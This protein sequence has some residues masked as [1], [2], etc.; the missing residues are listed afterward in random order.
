[1]KKKVLT[2]LLVVTMLLSAIP[3]FANGNPSFVVESVTAKAGETIDVTISVVNNP[4]IAS[5][6]LKVNYDTNLILNSV[7]YNT[8]IG[9]MSMQPQKLNSPVTLNWFN[10]IADTNGDWVFATL[11]F[12]VADTAT[13]G[14]CPITVTYEADNVYNIAEEN[15]TFEIENGGV[16][17][18]CSHEAKTE[19]PSKSADCVNSGNNL[20]YICDS[21]GQAF[22]T[23]G[24]TKTT[25]EA[26]TIPAL[27]HDYNDPTCTAPKTCKRC[28]VTEGEALGHD[29]V[30]ATCTAPKTCKRCGVTEGEALGHTPSDWQRDGENHWKNCAVCGVELEKAAHSDGDGNGAC[31]ACGYPMATVKPD[32]PATGDPTSILLL[33]V[34]LLSSGACLTAMIK[35]RKV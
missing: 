35:R 4:G 11:S 23:D 27:G 29:Y 24:V 25:V 31:D 26:E 1:M 14:T 17:I 7:T 32:I 15:I 28:G 33:A 10:G 22:K 13:V 3:V 16:A 21:C 30:E 20:Y 9:G 6:K 5:I 34:L 19:V 18:E 2:V 12:T 8:A